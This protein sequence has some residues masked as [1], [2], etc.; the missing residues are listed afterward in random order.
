MRDWQKNDLTFD[1]VDI[2]VT[3][4]WMKENDDGEYLVDGSKAITPT[5]KLS[6]LFSSIFI[7]F[8]M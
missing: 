7:R 3:T 5:S 4:D 1:K 6:F 8:I 2:A